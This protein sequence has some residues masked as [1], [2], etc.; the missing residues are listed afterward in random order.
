MMGSSHTWA[1]PRSISWF[2]PV[3]LRPTLV[4]GYLRKWALFWAGL[5]VGIPSTGHLCGLYCLGPKQAQDLLT[6]FRKGL[7]L[8]S[9]QS[10]LVLYSWGIFFCIG[11]SQQ[12]V[13]F[14]F[15]T[16][17]CISQ[18][19]TFVKQLEPN[20]NGWEGRLLKPH[21]KGREMSCWK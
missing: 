6:P 7:D 15:R 8:D 3:I 4:T 19:R 9:I 13:S 14:Y 18:K 17:Q 11:L 20:L 16:H 21:A 1:S 10:P 5:E 2:R 12:T